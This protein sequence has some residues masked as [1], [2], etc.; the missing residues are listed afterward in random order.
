M[1]VS[2]LS[3]NVNIALASYV[4]KKLKLCGGPLTD[5]LKL[6]HKITK[7][8]LSN[9]YFSWVIF[10]S[11]NYLLKENLIIIFRS[12]YVWKLRQD[13][14]PKITLELRQKITSV[15]KLR[16]KTMQMRSKNFVLITFWSYVRITLQNSR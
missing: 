13:Y 1:N 8:Y 11:G 15:R 9:Y 4:I 2:N 5:P 14:L 12:Y 16:N 6:D 3:V 7:Y 10:V